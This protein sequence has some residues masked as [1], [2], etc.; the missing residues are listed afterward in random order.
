MRHRRHIPP[1]ALRTGRGYDRTKM[2]QR[3]FNKQKGRCALCGR[4]MRLK[5]GGFDGN[6]ATIDHVQP[7][8]K[9]GLDVKRNLQA[10]CADCNLAKGDA[11]GD[12]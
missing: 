6:R 5:G 11:A 9:G 8:S 1:R 3:L 2:R 10:A 4:Q 12:G 7:L